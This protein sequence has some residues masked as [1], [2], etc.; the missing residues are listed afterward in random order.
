MNE[1]TARP[2]VPE[3]TLQ[4]EFSHPVEAVF[5]AWTRSDALRR[6]M[7]PGEVCAPESEI[8][9]RPGGRII[10]PMVNPDGRV[11]TARGEILEIVPNRKLRFSWAWDQEDGSPGQRMEITLEFEPAGDGS[12]LTFRQV[13]FI[14]AEAREKHQEGW[15]AC[16]DKLARHLQG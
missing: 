6:W 2:A 15:A 4:R 7:G 13:N 16:L 11:H 3:L 5:A 9:P 8:D 12:R 14:D 1:S 10:I